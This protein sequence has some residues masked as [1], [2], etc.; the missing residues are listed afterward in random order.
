MKDILFRKSLDFRDIIEILRPVII[1]ADSSQDIGG[2]LFEQASVTSIRSYPI[3][4]TLKDIRYDSD[5]LYSEGEYGEAPEDFHFHYPMGMVDLGSV[6]SDIEGEFVGFD[7]KHLLD[8]PKLTDLDRPRECLYTKESIKDG[9]FIPFSYLDEEVQ[10]DESSTPTHYVF[11][12]ILSERSTYLGWFYSISPVSGHGYSFNNDGSYYRGD[13]LNDEKNGFGEFYYDNG[14]HYDGYWR[15][16]TKQG[17][18]RFFFNK[19]LY[20]SGQ[21]VENKMI[22]CELQY[23]SSICNDIQHVYSFISSRHDYIFFKQSQISKSGVTI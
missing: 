18:G 19:D 10:G 2:R 12:I 21:W 7:P 16:N 23:T 15:H 17:N 13:I 20:Y 4:R 8:Y 1:P 14:S 5:Y 9:N 11:A 6:D 3:S 22:D